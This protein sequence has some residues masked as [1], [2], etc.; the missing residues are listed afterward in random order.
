M[1][2]GK[3]NVVSFDDLLSSLPDEQ[4]SKELIENL[5]SYYQFELSQLIHYS[6]PAK[7]PLI[8]LYPFEKAGSQ[9]IANFWVKDLALPVKNEYN[10]HGQNTSQWLYAGGILVQDGRV[11]THH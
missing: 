6:K 10:W 11:S 5:R 1:T 2:I 8:A 4:K 3:F 7:E 9:Y